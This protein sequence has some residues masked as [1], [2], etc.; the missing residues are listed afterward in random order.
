VEEAVA[1]G[2]D[3]GIG[4][5]REEAGVRD[6]A[7]IRRQVLTALRDT[8]GPAGATRVARQLEMG[9]VEAHARTVRF[10]LLA[11]EREGLVRTVTRRRGRV[12]TDRGSAELARAPAIGK[13][14]LVAARIDALA[15]RM[16]F[17]A[18]SGRGTIVVNTALVRRGY[19][20]RAIE[21][22][23]HVVRAQLSLGDRILVAREGE[24]IGDLHVPKDHVAIATVCSVTWTGILMKFGI[25]VT[26]RFGGLLEI[27]DG[28]PLRFTEL[29]EYAGTTLDPLEVFIGAKM[30]SVRQCAR[31]RSGVIGAGFREVPALALNDV[32]TVRQLTQRRG[33]GD[34]LAVGRANQPLLG[35]PVSEGRAGIVVAAGLNPIA[36]MI[37]AGADVSIQSLAGLVDYGKTVNLQEFRNRFPL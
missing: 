37:E 12:L 17:S 16:G 4:S 9:G 32:Q 2:R 25:P 24:T 5:G 19:L 7:E 26:S 15:Y 34:I 35:I 11:L 3:S 22:A 10:H 6:P 13:L 21:E 28:R 23:N 33:L 20:E 30:T 29:I 36:A 18:T 8:G 1:G 27:R 31:T 14:G